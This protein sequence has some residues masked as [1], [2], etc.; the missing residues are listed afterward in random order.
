MARTS[1]RASS[2]A[3]TNYAVFA[4]QGAD[5]TALQLSFLGR[6]PKVR[7]PE[8]TLAD[9]AQRTAT[10]I[11]EKEEKAEVKKA[12]QAAKEAQAASKKQAKE[13]R[14]AAG[15]AAKEAKAAAK[16]KF[17]RVDVVVFIAEMFE[18]KLK[19]YN[20]TADTMTAALRMSKLDCAGGDS[21]VGW[22]KLTDRVNKQFPDCGMRPEHMYRK[23]GWFS[24]VSVKK[25]SPS[26][27]NILLFLVL[28]LSAV[29]GLE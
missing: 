2:T 10:E 27:H 29:Q 17:E 14:A 5:P 6:D 21:Q 28:S 26:L 25:D 22:A 24:L 16:V 8:K 19:E 15:R 9:E 13:A 4:S 12:E 20:D 18:G 3:I 11:R 23:V 1:S 7:G